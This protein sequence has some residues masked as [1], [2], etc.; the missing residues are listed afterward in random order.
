MGTEFTPLD[1]IGK[2]AVYQHKSFPLFAYVHGH[3]IIQNSLSPISKASSLL[4]VQMLFKSPTFNKTQ[5]PYTIKTGE[6]GPC[7]ADKGT[8]QQA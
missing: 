6:L 3:T 8:C 2:S 1:S 7:L 5:A 4:T